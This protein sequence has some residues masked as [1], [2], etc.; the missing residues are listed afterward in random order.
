M[1]GILY[2]LPFILGF[3][4]LYSSEFLCEHPRIEFK[5]KCYLPHEYDD[6]KEK[7]E[8]EGAVKKA[9]EEKI[10]EAERKLLEE[11]ERE[12]K[13]IKKNFTLE[14]KGILWSDRSPRPLDH[15]TARKHCENLGGRLPSIDELRT[16]LTMCAAV[17]TGG[18]CSVS[19]GCLNRVNCR[20]SECNGCASASGGRYSVFGDT[21]WF[22]TSSIQADNK[23]K[24]WYI[25]FNQGLIDTE[26]LKT[27]GNVRCVSPQSE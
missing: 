9:E 14:N 16:L 10:K 6:V 23:T 3:A 25:N 1:K 22:W 24:G 19:S 8:K 21:G 11:K 18:A 13:L 20:T 17:E 15:A 4:F 5:G 7:A 2:S 26:N 27:R 12:E